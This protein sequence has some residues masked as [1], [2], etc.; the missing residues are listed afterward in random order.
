[1]SMLWKFLHD[2]YLDCIITISTHLHDSKKFPILCYL[3]EQS[4]AINLIVEMLKLFGLERCATERDAFGRNPVLCASIHGN[5]RALEIFLE[6]PE[7][8]VLAGEDGQTP[9]H[10]IATLN[11]ELS[12]ACWR[13][14][15]PHLSA[16][17][18]KRQDQS[19]KTALHI[20]SSCSPLEVVRDMLSDGAVN[21]INT[22]DNEGIT[23]LWNA[24]FYGRVEIV[25]LLLSYGAEITG[26]LGAACYSKNCEIFELVWHLDATR[27]VDPRTHFTPFLSACRNSYLPAM[28][29]LLELYPASVYD[30]DKWGDGPLHNIFWGTANPEEK[31]IAAQLLQYHNSRC[32]L[33]KD[34]NGAG[35]LIWAI[36]APFHCYSSELLNWM[37]RL[38]PSVV[39][40]ADLEGRPPIWHA[41]YEGN[42]GA[43]NDLI[44]FPE[45]K[46]SL[47]SLPKKVSSDIYRFCGTTE[48]VI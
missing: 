20:A 29:R 18:W 13:V 37:Y 45:V 14:L 12:L 4:D 48:K 19:G 47:S 38:Y 31:L 16:E 43:F 39:V 6:S 17:W 1:M 8:T 44:V 7:L 15:R 24:A 41:A 34:R 22:P 42:I 26:A 40:D 36:N 46:I 27:Y 5:Y 30:V 23:S 35:P 28:K 10:A 21:I 2:E 25:K 32:L 11:P 33:E 9:A 3:A